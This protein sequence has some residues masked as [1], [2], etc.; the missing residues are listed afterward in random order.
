MDEFFLTLQDAVKRGLVKDELYPDKTPELSETWLKTPGRHR[1]PI[2]E[3]LAEELV[4]IARAPSEERRQHIGDA[5]WTDLVSIEVEGVAGD[6]EK[7][8]TR[9]KGRTPPAVNEDA[10]AFLYA[11][12][13][14]AWVVIRAAIEAQGIYA[15]HRDQCL[16]DFTRTCG[17]IV[18]VAPFEKLF[19]AW[20]GWE[21]GAPSVADIAAWSEG[22]LT[23]ARTLRDTL[24]P[25]ESEA[26]FTGWPPRT[27]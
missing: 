8:L 18:D 10:D 6:R 25:D 16:N 19:D 2:A 1:L 4:R 15:N 7:F 26:S 23:G 5:G 11:A 12:F 27:I 17:K 22:V 9:F 13:T 24:G 14:T 3:K 21:K 20:A